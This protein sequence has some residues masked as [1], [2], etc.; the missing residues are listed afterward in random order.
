MR[1]VLCQGLY[2]LYLILTMHSY[3]LYPHFANEK[4]EAQ[5]KLLKIT[6]LGRAGIQILFCSK[7][8]SYVLAGPLA[9]FSE[10]SVIACH[11]SI[12]TGASSVFS[13]SWGHSSCSD[14]S[15]GF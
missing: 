8:L 12:Y 11:V 14:F 2:L 6:Q 5:E 4:T 1:Q 9:W 13:K 10:P 7:P 15:L 3:Y